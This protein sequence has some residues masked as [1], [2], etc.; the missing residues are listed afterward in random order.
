[1]REL[2]VG[3]SRISN[4]VILSPSFGRRISRNVS[5]LL[6]VS[7]LFYEC[8]SLPKSLQ[9]AI[10]FERL[11]EILRPKEGLRMTG[12]K[13]QFPV[14]KCVIFFCLLLLSSSAFS[15]NDKVQ[16][17]VTKGVE[18]VRIAVA[19]FKAANADPNTA[20][21]LTTFNQVLYS[22][23]QNAG[24]F[25]VVSKSFNPLDTPSSPQDVK[26]DAWGNPPANAAML[27]FGNLG[28]SGGQVAVYG[29]LY[30]V[31]NTVA[32]QVLGKQYREDATPDNARLIAHRFADEI[33]FRLGGG[34]PGVAESK[35]V[36]VSNRTGTKEIWMMDYDGY[37]EHQITHLGSVSLSPRISPD[38]SRIA[39]VELGKRSV[40]IR[41]YSL[42]LNRLVTFPSIGGTT[43]SP[44]WS[45]DGSHLAFSS[46]RTGDPEIY[47]SNSAGGEL[48]RITEAHGPDVSP[49]WNPKTGAQ[50]AW[51][52]GRSGLP[53]IYTMAAD[54][55][56]PQRM[57][58]TGYAVSPSWSP[59]GQWLAFAWSRKYGPGIPGG[60]DI[61]IMDVASKQWSQL[62]HDSGT[63]DF[64]S[65][66]PDGRHIIFQSNRTG[67][68]QI[69]TMLADGTQ[70]QQLTH[71]GQNSQ[72]N[73]SWK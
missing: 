42:D 19:D 36:F 23:L 14:S 24:I 70:Q 25:D 41:M 58:D 22:D 16:V 2:I 49:V 37:G 54:G 18:R 38:N 45:P 51:V 52:S 7:G 35:I 64:P 65:W 13:K 72:P 32:P 10:K 48:K 9:R 40:N 5:G 61:Y 1:L 59:D 33:I 39:F 4:S 29:W 31:K 47:V 63:N 12:I 62:T 55:T 73:W 26:I 69:W 68:T 27:A 15:Q 53:Q 46:S 28:V 11:R 6:A 30:D 3:N 66:S 67:T 8:L 34:I 60:Q 57:T 50:I 44:A 20:A 21:L 43:L 56:N 17:I 71:T